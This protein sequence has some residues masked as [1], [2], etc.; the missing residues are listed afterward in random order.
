MSSPFD[1][2]F[3]A[4]S[5]I[6]ESVKAESLASGSD[7]VQGV[8]PEPSLPPAD[9][10]DDDEEPAPSRASIGTTH[11]GRTRQNVRRCLLGSQ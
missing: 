3:G 9:A 10:M 1:P 11:S 4:K 5:E 2:V 6:D 8:L 7:G